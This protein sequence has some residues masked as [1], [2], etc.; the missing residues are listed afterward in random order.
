MN[1]K[2]DIEDLLNDV[3]AED[4]PMDFREASLGDTLRR[5]RRRRRVRKGFQG[6]VCI[7]IFGVLSFLFWPGHEKQPK[8][9]P[10]TAKIEKGYKIVH[11]RPMPADSIVTT[12]ATP[13]EN[14]NI[15]KQSVAIVQTK[16]GEYRVINDEE[17]LALL[18]SR[19]AAL[20]R[21]GPDSEEL[22]FINP[23]NQKAEPVN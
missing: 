16:H 19:P 13:F 5:V 15:P 8:Q 12:R 10:V 2:P 23:E 17:L 18:G 11:T 4:A 14:S 20:I 22:V 3:F 6:A 9:A 1:R 7:M 21:L